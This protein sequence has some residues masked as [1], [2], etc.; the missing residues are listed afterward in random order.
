MKY[1]IA[2]LH[3]IGLILFPLIMIPLLQWY[4]R[5]FCEPN[6]DLYGIHIVVVFIS[7]GMFIMTIF[8][9]VL[10]ITNKDIKDL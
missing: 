10:A 2:I 9:W 7:F 4:K 3:T 1:L 6:T 5:T 8:R